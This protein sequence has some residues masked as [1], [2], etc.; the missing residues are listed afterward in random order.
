MIFATPLIRGGN[1]VLAISLNLWRLPQTNYR[2]VTIALKNSAL[3]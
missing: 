3:L 1:G 2:V